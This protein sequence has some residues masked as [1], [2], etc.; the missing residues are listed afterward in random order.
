MFGSKFTDTVMKVHLQKL[1]YNNNTVM[2]TFV[3]VYI[4][5]SVVVVYI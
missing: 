4:C 5:H 3:F 2:R 1:P